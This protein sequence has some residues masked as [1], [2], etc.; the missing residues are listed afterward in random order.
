M[1]ARTASQADAARIT[2][3]EE[4]VAQ[5]AEAGRLLAPDIGTSE[6]EMAWLLDTYNTAA[7]MSMTS[8][9][10]GKPVVIGG[11]SG[12]RRAT[13]FGVAECVKFAAGMLSMEPPVT[14]AVSGFGDV[15]QAAAEVLA[16]EHGFEVVAIGDVSG[17]RYDES[18]L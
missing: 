16:A 10:T 18:G 3:W 13:G 8:P 12:R 9:V 4:A 11:S 15:G 5:L 7:G 1:E 2:P 6:Q 14:V 17:G